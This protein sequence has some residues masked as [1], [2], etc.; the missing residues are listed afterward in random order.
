MFKIIFEEVGASPPK[1]LPVI[2]YI[3]GGAFCVGSSDPRLYGPEYLIDK[4][5]VYVSINYRLGPLGFF[6]LGND[7]AP[8]NQVYNVKLNREFSFGFTFINYKYF[9]V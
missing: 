8:G 7:Q 4:G 2:V 5:I 1:P 6:S 3:H 9:H